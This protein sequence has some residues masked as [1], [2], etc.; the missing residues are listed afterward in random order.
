MTTPVEMPAVDR[1]HPGER[2]AVAPEE[3]LRELVVCSLEPWDEIWR[4]NQFFVDAL[5]RRNRALRVLFIEPPADVLFDIAQRRRPDLPRY[6]RLADDGRLVAFRPIKAL[7]RRLGPLADALLAWQL[8]LVA[9]RIGFESPVLWINDVTYAPLIEQTGWP[10]LYDVTDDWLLA[11]SPPRELERLRRLDA[12]ALAHA[13]EVVVC[14][15]ALARSR[16]TARP[17]TLVPNGVDVDH[18]RRPRRRPPD[19]PTAPTAVHVGSLHDARLDVELVAQVADALPQ[20]NVVLVGPDSLGSDSRSLLAS[21]PNVSLLGARPYEEVPA[22]LQHA[23]VIIVPHR[24]TPFTESL[25]PIKAYE[26][27]AMD[28]PTVATPVAGFRIHADVLDVV[29]GREFAAHV[30]EVLK[31]P[32]PPPAG[33]GSPVSW[34]DRVAAFE[35]VLDRVS[36]YAATDARSRTRE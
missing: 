13:D 6:R 20:V 21:R 27:L 7:P 5:L 19:L 22:Y 23:D 31:S 24:V 35:S 17:V 29:E 32:P 14:S 9:R 2:A 25:D 1:P 12:V 34:E 4:R 10:S 28:T 15:S 16:G 11:P 33:V 3:E 30:R 36:A 26:C 18:F 8:R